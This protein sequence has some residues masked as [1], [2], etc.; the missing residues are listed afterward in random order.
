MWEDEKNKNG[1]KW[2]LKV[3]KGYGS[4]VWEEVVCAHT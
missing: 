3:Q 2:T 1:G 4:K